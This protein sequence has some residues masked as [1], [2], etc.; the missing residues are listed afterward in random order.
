VCVPQML[1]MVKEVATNTGRRTCSPCATDTG[2]LKEN[3]RISTFHSV[4]GQ[5]ADCQLAD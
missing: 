1:S 2:R 3:R 5:L 4:T